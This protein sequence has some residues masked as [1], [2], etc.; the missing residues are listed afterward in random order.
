MKKVPLGIVSV[1]GQRETAPH[2]LIGKF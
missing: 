2:H 1:V